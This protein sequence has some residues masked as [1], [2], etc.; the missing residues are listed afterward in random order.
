MARVTWTPQAADDLEA[1]C[2]YIARDSTRYAQVFAAEVISS[3]ERLAVFPRS[4]RVVPEIEREDI[5]EIIVAGY[6]LIYRLKNEEVQILTLHH[7][8]RLLDKNSLLIEG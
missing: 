6:R 1:T 5:R 4:G 7:G 3:T 2:L 8:A